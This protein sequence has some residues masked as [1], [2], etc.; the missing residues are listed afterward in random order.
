MWLSADKK[1]CN[2]SHV[3]HSTQ[4]DNGA[5]VKLKIVV[6]KEDLEEVLELMR[7][8]NDNN[9][10]PNTA[11]DDNSDEDEEDEEALLSMDERL[12]QWRKNHTLPGQAL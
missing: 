5:A 4:E 1:Y 3:G 10:N 7:N 6:M 12:I 11:D 8:Y 2:E 9:N